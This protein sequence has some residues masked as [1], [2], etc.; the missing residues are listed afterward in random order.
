MADTR[1]QDAQLERFNLLCGNLPWTILGALLVAITF[2]LVLEAQLPLSVRLPWLVFVV[3]LLLVR[4]W[5]LHS[6][7]QVP[8][9]TAN[10]RQRVTHTTVLG[11]LTAACFGFIGFMGATPENPTI[12]VLV[13]MLCT[14]M[15]AGA[16]AAYSHMVVMYVLY[17]FTLMLPLA[18]RLYSFNDDDFRLM[19]GLILAY[20]PI[21]LG[22]SRS[23]RASIMR[24]INLRYANIT[25][26]DNLTHEKQRAEQALASEEQANL[27]KSRFLAAASHDLRQPLHSLR[28]FTTTLALQTSNSQHK[29]LVAQIDSSVKSLEE[30]FNA[31][32]DISKLDAGTVV[33]DKRHMHLDILLSQ[34]KEELTPIAD[35]RGLAFEVA[36][37]DHVLHTDALLLERLLRN[38]IS[39]AIRYTDSGKVCI[40]T[41]RSQD[42]SLVWIT[43]ADTGMGI[44][45]ADQMRVFDEFVQ[46]DNEERDRNRGIGLGLSIVKRLGKLLDVPIELTS[47]EGKGSLFKVGV[48]MGDAAQIASSLPGSRPTAVNDHVGSL[49][50]LVIDDEEEVCLAIESLLETWGCVVM[51]ATSGTAA[52]QQLAEI[53]EVPDII[54]SDYRLRGEETG[55]DV[56][57]DIRRSL[58]RDI[59][60]IILTGDIAPERLIDIKA[61]GL[62]TLHKPCE[63]DDLRYLLAQQTQPDAAMA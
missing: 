31:L 41:Q 36:L 58:A 45:E 24:S 62:P 42:N 8:N 48:P 10:V 17:L 6:Y 22:I 51:S 15:V 12:N 59:P 2:F 61:L 32:L 50:V 47:E 4:V 7:T 18:F 52:L 37:E 29:D 39:N 63:P 19:A 11:T 1:A 23:T 5:L 44:P 34:I 27:A 3:A 60:A 54:V 16:T 21:C 57:F 43:V 9:T 26:L 30:L 25:L 40:S 33:V 38:L 55:G 49:F 28:L 20:L 53:G 46:L 14:G 35:E 56:V 13:V